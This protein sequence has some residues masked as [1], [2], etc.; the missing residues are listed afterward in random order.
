MAW[1]LP[2]GSP[3]PLPWREAAPHLRDGNRQDGD[4]THRNA[5]PPLLT[6]D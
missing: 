4:W 5:L 1:N 2:S 6:N 3:V